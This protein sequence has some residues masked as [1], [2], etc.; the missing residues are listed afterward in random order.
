MSTKWQEKEK[1]KKMKTKN[2]KRKKEKY[3][4]RSGGVGEERRHR[5]LESV[6]EIRT[7]KFEDRLLKSRVEARSSNFKI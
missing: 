2:R 6:F 5:L 4:M 1:K 3:T 7:S